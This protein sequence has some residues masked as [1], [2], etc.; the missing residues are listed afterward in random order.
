MMMLDNPVSRYVQTLRQSQWA[1]VEDLQE[2]QRSLLERLLSHAIAETDAYPARLTPVTNAQGRIDLA[3][4]SE[5]PFLQRSDLQDRQ[6]VFRAR[7]VPEATGSIVPFST[8]GSTGR[9]IHFVKSAL[10][11]HSSRA[12]VERAHDW[13]EADRDLPYV[14]ISV[15][16]REI[17]PPPDGQLRARWSHLG[18]E[19]RHGFLSISAPISV[20][21][22]FLN[23]MRPAYLKTYPTNIAALAR[24]ASGLPWHSNLR[25]VFTFAETLADDQVD[26]VREKLGVEITDFYASEESGQMATRC[27]HSNMYHV[28]AESNLVEVLKDDNTPCGPG[29]SGR[30]VVTPFYN[31]ALPLIRYEQNDIAELPMQPCGCGRSL[32]TIKRILGRTRD[33]FV[34]PDGDRVWPQLRPPAVMK[35]LPARQWQAVQIARDHIEVRYVD[36]GSGREPDQPAFQDYVHEKFAPEIALTLVQVDK[37]ERSAGGKFREFISLVE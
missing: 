15:D 9:P 8:S 13:A 11:T 30:V 10:L 26:I 22:D 21:V 17:G 20:Q 34:L 12:I 36:D 32:P 2:M 35:F 28:A 6:D 5:L 16:R 23:R 7:T 18:G 33:M 14:T 31:Y 27:P 4:W 19:G 29:E 1:S 3:R 24:Y 37:I 25:H